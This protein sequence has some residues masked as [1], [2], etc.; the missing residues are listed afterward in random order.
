M[1]T[2]Q[3]NIRIFQTDDG[4]EV[5]I[6]NGIFAADGGLE[7]MA[8]LCLFGGNEEDD[9]RAENPRK[10]WG[11]LTEPDQ[12]RHYVSRTDEMLLRCDPLPANLKRVE[13]AALQD[14]GVFLS[15]GI[16]SSVAVAASIP[17][18]NSI[19][20]VVTIEAD[21]TEQQFEFVENWR[22]SA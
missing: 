5:S 8:Y 9:G 1:T 20:I 13:D 2:E 3:G 7:S 6:V 22:A 15:A 18:L 10:W 11:N 17:G 19:R 12:S 14:L 16:A 4:G 21:G